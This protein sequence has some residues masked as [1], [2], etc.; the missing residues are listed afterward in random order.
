MLVILSFYVILSGYVPINT[1]TAPVAVVCI[2]V[3][4][5]GVLGYTITVLNPRHP[6]GA[7]IRKKR[8]HSFSGR[9]KQKQLM[10]I[11]AKSSAHPF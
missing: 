6:R 8:N 9:I 2:G 5:F 7:Q 3:V 10:V 1:F 11:L 4:V